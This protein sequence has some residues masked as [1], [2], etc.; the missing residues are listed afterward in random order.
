MRS[1]RF[2]SDLYFRL[3][4]LTIAVPPL[5]E[6]AEDIPA[7][8]DDYVHRLAAECR[9]DVR[10][11][12]AAL[13]KLRQHRWP[14][15]VRELQ[16]VLEKAVVNTEGAEVDADSLVLLSTNRTR[17]PICRSISKQIERVWAIPEAIKRTGGQQDA[18]RHGCSASPARHWPRKWKSTGSM[19]KTN[20]PSI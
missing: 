11:T 9:R 17:R 15:N 4:A 8:A 16:R 13:Q 6:H 2:R 12:A 14:G 19:G 5:R 1:G 3:K 7:I 20:P 18:C 10:L